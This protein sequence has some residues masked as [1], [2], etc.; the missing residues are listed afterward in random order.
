M[1]YRCH[2]PGCALQV[3]TEASLA[4]HAS[5]AHGADPLVCRECG[6]VLGDPRSLTRHRDMHINPRAY[7]CMVCPEGFYRVDSLASHIYRLHFQDIWQFALDHGYLAY[8]AA[9]NQPVLA[10]NQAA[11]PMHQPAVANHFD[12]MMHHAAPPNLFPHMHPM[13]QAAPADYYDPAMH[14]AAPMNYFIPGFR[15]PAAPMDE[16]MQMAHQQPAPLLYQAAPVDN[17]QAANQQSAAE[18]QYP[19]PAN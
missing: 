4:A 14:H 2:Y 1:A 17:P 12:P 19:D 15:Q 13:H 8:L 6:A 7:Q 18:N 16:P 5:A 10:V 3:A 9:A 11:P